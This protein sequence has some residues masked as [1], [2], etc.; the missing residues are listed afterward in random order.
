MF[1]LS[2]Y[3]LTLLRNIL[4]PKY[5]VLNL[6]AM[7]VLL[8]LD[9]ASSFMLFL[10]YE[11]E[12][13]FQLALIPFLFVY[14]FTVILSPIAALLSIF[15][16]KAS[17]YRMFLNVNA[18]TCTTNIFLTFIFEFVFLFIVKDNNKGQIR[19]TDSIEPM[20]LCLLKMVFKIQ[21][22]YFACKQLAFNNNNSFHENR[23]ELMAIHKK[24]TDEMTDLGENKSHDQ[25]TNE[26]S[27]VFKN[28]DSDDDK[29]SFYK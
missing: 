22:G 27:R 29:S 12:R 11:H 6:S 28:E 21:L 8:F 16:C 14:P 18:L 2:F 3:K 20:I 13:T 15:I 19:S 9:T 25:Q 5:P 1:F 17:F 23:K 4:P 24:V 10:L 26:E 7:V